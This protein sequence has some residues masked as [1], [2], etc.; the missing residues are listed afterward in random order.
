MLTCCLYVDQTGCCSR[1]D[2]L[3]TANAT[4][5]NYWVTAQ[6]QYRMGSP[7]GFA[8]LQYAGANETLPATPTPQPGAVEPWS[9]PQAAMVRPYRGHAFAAFDVVTQACS[10]IKPGQLLS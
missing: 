3:L 8:V 7:N 9:E 2:V 5:G 1:Y 10:V 6:P 4:A